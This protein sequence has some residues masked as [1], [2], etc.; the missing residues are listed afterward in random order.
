MQSEGKELSEG[1]GSSSWRRVVLAV[2]QWLAEY[3][4]KSN[5]EKRNRKELSVQ[6]KS[7]A[8]INDW[9]QLPLEVLFGF[10]SFVILA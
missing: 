5:Q 3:Q 1:Q 4:I 9:V 8:I 2:F 6:K 10:I 7:E